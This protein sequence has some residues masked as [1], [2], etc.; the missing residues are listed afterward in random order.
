MGI[1]ARLLL[2]ISWLISDA[3]LA[4]FGLQF[5]CGCL[6]TYL[7]S[8][9]GAIPVNSSWP[10]IIWESDWGLHSKA[11]SEHLKAVCSG[12]NLSCSFERF[13]SKSRIG[14]F[15]FLSREWATE[16]TIALDHLREATV[17]MERENAMLSAMK[18]VNDMYDQERQAN[19]LS[20]EEAGNR[21][22]QI[23]DEVHLNMFG[24]G[25]QMVSDEHRGPD[26]Y[27]ESQ[28]QRAV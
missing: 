20:P 23:F 2:V 5:C 14:S 25:Y 18:Q 22:L 7:L 12:V 17:R 10:R 19:N 8:Q 21:I 26:G 27:S 16:Q 11:T 6:R 9:A 3:Y 1:A 15:Y 13:H 4:A 28:G 24:A